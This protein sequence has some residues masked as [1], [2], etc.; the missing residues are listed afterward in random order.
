MLQLLLQRLISIILVR[1][2][3]LSFPFLKVKHD[4]LVLVINCLWLGQIRGLLDKPD[5]R[6]VKPQALIV[7]GRLI[8]RFFQS[9]GSGGAVLLDIPSLFVIFSLLLAILL[10]VLNRLKQLTIDLVQ[11]LG[12][13]MFVAKLKLAECDV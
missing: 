3:H 8:G 9:V 2:V 13:E 12:L 6:V 4:L 11:P 1:Q 5:S 7:V 10:H